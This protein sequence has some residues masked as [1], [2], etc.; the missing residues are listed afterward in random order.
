MTKLRIAGVLPESLVDGPGVRS[1]LFVQG[2]TLECDGCHSPSTW[3]VNGGEEHD[4]SKIASEL[5]KA[6]QIR[7]ITISGGEPFFQSKQISMLVKKLKIINPDVNI[8]IYTGLTL[9]KLFEKAKNDIFVK[10]VLLGVDTLVA[11]PY[12]KDKHD[13]SLKFRGSKNQ[14]IINREEYIAALE[15]L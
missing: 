8:W 2:C 14:K 10:E 5:L 4:I 12:I 13:I 1:V 3:D 6:N 7:G 11:G 9:K 15:R